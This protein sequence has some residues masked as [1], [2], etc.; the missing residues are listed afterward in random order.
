MLLKK[1]NLNILVVD[2]NQERSS[3]LSKI[4]EEGKGGKFFVTSTIGKAQELLDRERYHLVVVGD[5]FLAEEK[6]TAFEAL[7]KAIQKRSLPWIFYTSSKDMS[8]IRNAVQEGFSA[9]LHYPFEEHV[10]PR[11]LLNCLRKDN[12]DEV[13]ES[14]HKAEFFDELSEEEINELLRVAIPRRFEVGEEIITRGD[15]AD[16]FYVL[17]KGQVMAIIA[18][19]GKNAVDVPIEEGSPFGEMAILDNSP[20]SAWC[21]ASQE[22]LVLEIGSHIINDSTYGLRL[23]LFAKIAVILAGRIRKMNKL[24]DKTIQDGYEHVMANPEDVRVFDAMASFAASHD[25]DEGYVDFEAHAGE[26]HE[27]SSEEAYSEGELLESVLSEGNEDS[28]EEEAPETEGA[29]ETEEGADENVE[30]M[31]AKPKKIEEENPFSVPTGEAE[32]YDESVRSDEEYDVLVRKIN[33]RAD[34]I[35]AKVPRTLGE[36]VCN[37]MYGY[38][39]GSKLA[40]MNPHCQWNEKSFVP[41][42]PQLKHA[43]H[44]V[45]VCPDGDKAYKKVFLD[46]P[47]T[48]RVVGLTQIGC[49]GTLLG[50]DKTIERYLNGDKLEK[51]IQLDLETPI[52]RLWRGLEVIEFLTH[53]SADVRRETLFLVFDKEDGTYTHRVRE[54]FPDHQ[55]LTVV[56]GYGFNMDEPSS[57]FSMTEDLLQEKGFLVPKGAYTGEGTGFYN[58]ET[59]FFSDFSEFYKTTKSMKNYGY[60]FG[61]VGVVARV[62]P[63]YSGVVWGSRGGAEGAVKAA[64]AMFGVKGAQS[65]TDIASAVS[66]ADGN[67]PE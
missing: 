53:T 21:V 26:G 6:K 37:R 27:E 38:W 10:L 20:R 25:Q 9:V 55:I 1:L 59:V 36:M 51:A 14:V 24:I 42:S 67:I 19:K 17:L 13:S 18:K 62:G 56:K 40:R 41:G 60:V 64:K 66:W 34:F 52:D 43:L 32:E 7:K 48:H 23:K 5:D 44:L 12:S 28:A 4:L 31:I 8:F 29:K 63:D 2:S 22:S 35:V 58:G 46:L 47:L 45:V 33:L 3:L 65:S 61:T 57:M 39:V 50:S 15:P 54:K 30:K 16:G 11:V 49:S